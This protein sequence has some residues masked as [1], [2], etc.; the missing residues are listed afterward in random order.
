MAADYDAAR[1]TYPD[2]LYAAIARLAGADWDGL[3]VADIGAG[4]GI[5][6]RA[7][8][9]RGARVVALDLGAGMLRRLRAHRDPPPAAVARAEALPL[10]AGSVNVVTLAQAWHWVD[11]ERTAAEVVRV[12]RPGG[13]LAI[14]WNDVDA[15]GVDWWEAQQERIEAGNPDYERGYRDEDYVGPLRAT[16]RFAAVE[17]WIGRW[18]RR[19]DLDTYERWLR[20][21]SY[22]AALGAGLEDFIAAERASLSRAFPDGVVE[23]PFRVRLHVARL[24]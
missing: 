16:G 10:A 14:W 22:V 11:V 3:R 4:T 20:S 1:P 24:P 2:D 19:I 18:E 8:T 6:S 15:A 9:T 12:C 5:A 17:T 13:A 7:M 23:E 21:K